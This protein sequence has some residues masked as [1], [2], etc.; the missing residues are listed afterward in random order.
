MDAVIDL[1]AE[2]II[3]NVSCKNSFH[4]KRVPRFRLVVCLSFC[5]L[6]RSTSHVIVIVLTTTPSTPS[7]HSRE[8]RK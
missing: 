3:Y 6:L 2:S 8:V 5:Q 7:T 1:N 4:W